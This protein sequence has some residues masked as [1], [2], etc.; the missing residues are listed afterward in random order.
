MSQSNDV[1]SALNAADN[2]I[3]KYED[4][5]NAYQDTTEKLNQMIMGRNVITD[6]EYPPPQPRESKEDQ[7]EEKEEEDLGGFAAAKHYC[8]HIASAL[9]IPRDINKFPKINEFPECDVADCDK[10]ENWICLKCHRVFCGR[11]GNKHMVKH[12]NES[13]QKHCIA[14]GV[15]DL[16]FWC[17][18]CD[19]YLHHL[20]IKAVFDLYKIVH[21]IKFGEAIPK[22]L[23]KE[24]DFMDCDYDQNEHE[25]VG[26]NPQDNPL[27]Q[28]GAN[29]GLGNV[30]SG[31]DTVLEEDQTE[32]FDSNDV[33]SHKAKKLAQLILSS[34]YTVIHTGAGV[35]T[36]ANLPDYRGPNGVWTLKAKGKSVR[37]KA[38][39]NIEDASPTYCHM[40]L[41]KLMQSK[42]LR[43]VVT[44]NVDGL[45]KKSGIE[46]EELAQLHGSIY[47]EFCNDCG[48]EYY[49]DYNVQQMQK[50]IASV[51]TVFTR[52]TGRKCENDSCEGKL[53]DSIIAFGES[54][55]G[56]ELGDAHSHSVKADLNI[57]IGSSM[58][59]APACSLPL[60]GKTFVLLNLQK[61]P[62]D[63]YANL[64]IWGKCDE[65]MKMVMDELKLNVEPYQSTSK[66][67]QN[68]ED[69]K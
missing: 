18:K 11:Y 65:V 51:A 66:D 33:L 55:P 19:D 43:F 64:R 28:S 42:L 31:K 36:A 47:M 14:M 4:M 48:Q 63:K 6:D 30:A 20:S 1:E 39:D 62:C 67:N 8:A 22:S 53:R 21:Q 27:T 26:R 41:V 69:D 15:G 13:N 17:Y 44:T 35:S 38:L 12:Y 58:R 37:S 59:V 29:R 10:K 34:K 56:T 16:S 49:R 40:A 50:S 57:V 5:V 23:E 32:Y 45:H 24:T 54:L 9:V 7:Q 25:I 52:F 60:Q 46:H 3:S 2:V 68:V 61:T